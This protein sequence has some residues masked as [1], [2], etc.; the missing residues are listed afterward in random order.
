LGWH[1]QPIIEDRKKWPSGLITQSSIQ[2]LEER[3]K[4]ETVK[5]GM[6]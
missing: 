3:V 5:T 2:S 6:R 1:E 4:K